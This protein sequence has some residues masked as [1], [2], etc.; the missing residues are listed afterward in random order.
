MCN[1]DSKDLYD[2]SNQVPAR[3]QST[4]AKAQGIRSHV[5]RVQGL[6]E[7]QSQTFITGRQIPCRQNM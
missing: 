4:H 2:L 6:Q 1:T 5:I 7:Y 3:R